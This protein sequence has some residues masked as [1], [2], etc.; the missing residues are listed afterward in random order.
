MFDDDN[1]ATESDLD[2]ARR[3]GYAE[4][5]SAE[6]ARIK[7]IM[8]CAEAQGKIKLAEGIAY[9]TSA[10]VKEAMGI[11][12]VATSRDENAQN[13]TDRA[14]RIAGIKARADAT[15]GKLVPGIR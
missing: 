7:A 5:A 9:G 12:A 11:L 4:G 14:A 1:S 6:R 13:A 3:R 2:A 8:N 10:N 15:Y